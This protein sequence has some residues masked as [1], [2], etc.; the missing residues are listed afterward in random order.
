M[1]KHKIH[2]EDL[3]GRHPGLTPGTALAYREAAE[4]CF[5]RHHSPPTDLSVDH[6]SQITAVAQWNL[7]DDRT[8]RGWANE[9]DATEAGA[10]CVAL[11]T[12][13]VTGEL[14]AISRAETRTG[15]DYYIAPKGT[16]PTDLEAAY[17]LEVSGIDEGD[18][19]SVKTRLNQKIKQALRG[20]SSL[21]AIAAVV[22]FSSANVAIADAVQVEKK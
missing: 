8:K 14:V 15:A 20:R 19:S 21:P 5:A 4:V 2:I 6:N 22:S 12:I 17:R 18:A 7:P 16:Q 1:Q 3:Q 13:E 9:T 10:Y 11:A